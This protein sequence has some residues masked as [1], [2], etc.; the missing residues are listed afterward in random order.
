MNNIISV[1]GT[2]PSTSTMHLESSLANNLITCAMIVILYFHIVNLAI[3]SRQQI[4]RCTSHTS[5]RIGA[6][7]YVAVNS[8]TNWTTHVAFR[9]PS[10]PH[11]TVVSNVVTRLG[12][13]NYLLNLHRLAQKDETESNQQHSFHT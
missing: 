10:I 9:T 5:S 8:I 11:W 3:H 1:E 13:P 2:R 6:G 7:L 12:I 4:C